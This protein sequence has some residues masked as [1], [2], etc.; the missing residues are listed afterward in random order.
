MPPKKKSEDKISDKE[1]MRIKRA[2]MSNEE[3]ETERKK[4]RKRMAKTRKQ[5]SDSKKEEVRA[6]DR[7]RK[8][9][10]SCDTEES[11]SHYIKHEKEY[12]RLYKIK[13]RKGRSEAEHE[14]EMI[15]NLLCMRRLRNSRTGK[16]HLLDN[17]E[18]RRGMRLVEKKVSIEPQFQ[19]RSFR[20]ID[21]VIV[22]K[23]FVDRGT[24]YASILEARNPE[25]AAEVRKILESQRKEREARE[26]KIKEREDRGFWTENPQTGEFWWTGK[27]PPGPEN[28]DPNMREYEQEIDV[29]EGE[30]ALTEQ[31]WDELQAKWYRE[32]MEE[33]RQEDRE[34]R[35]EQARENYKKRKEALS[36]PIIMPEVELSEYEKIR[37]Q[38][39]KERD[40][41]FQ[42]MGNELLNY[43]HL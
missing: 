33:R 43:N 27:E 7:E 14:Y 20:D 10:K 30:M 11:N 6:K 28:P 42:S 32:T 39:I 21:E 23:K 37:E 38:N 41:A 13:I 15:Y 34:A 24:Q 35:N 36:E 3:K 2:N 26:A 5:M 22:W 9:K 25:I 17:L 31:E 16:E 1:R 19:Q 12:N 8:P 29:W 18:A 40:E 4:A